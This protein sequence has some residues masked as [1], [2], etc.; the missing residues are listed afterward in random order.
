MTEV[1]DPLGAE[2][3]LPTAP[4]IVATASDAEPPFVGVVTRAVAWIVDALLINLAA[5]L[6]G[7][8][9]ALVLSI[10]PLGKSAEPV[11]QAIA[12]TAYVVWIAVYF[13]GFWSITGQ[14]PGARVMQ[15]RLLTAARQRVKPGRALVRWVGMNLAMLPLFAGY[16]PILF[17]R[18]GFPDWLAHTIVVDAPQMSLA[19]ERRASLEATRHGHAGP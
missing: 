3:T 15:I 16:V 12:G 9:T 13:V 17:G 11:F 4:T 2:A 19:E 18:R 5:I 6:A 14:T 10:F 7:L 1:I 8:G